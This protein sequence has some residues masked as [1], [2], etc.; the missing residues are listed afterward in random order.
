MSNYA[1]YATRRM[2]RNVSITVSLNIVGLMTS[3]VLRRNSGSGVR[4]SPGKL[5]IITE[6]IRRF[7]QRLLGDSTMWS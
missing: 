3:R 2:K 4:T 6:N 5:P 1:E 7:L